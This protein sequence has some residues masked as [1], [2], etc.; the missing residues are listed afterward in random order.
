MAARWKSLHSVEDAF[1]RA[2]D[3]YQSIVVNGRLGPAPAGKRALSAL[4]R[5][6]RV[7]RRAVGAVESL[8]RP[9]LAFLMDIPDLKG[10]FDTFWLA[11]KASRRRRP[12][13][14]GA[15]GRAG[16]GEPRSLGRCGAK[17]SWRRACPGSGVRGGMKTAGVGE[18]GAWFWRPCNTRPPTAFAARVLPTSLTA[19]GAS[20]LAQV[21]ACSA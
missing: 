13:G 21:P 14:S 18:P 7:G 20:P 4:L 5:A 19:G 2:M 6:I 9:P 10:K 8:G 17:G 1:I 11:T 15:P 3:S 12:L 16:R